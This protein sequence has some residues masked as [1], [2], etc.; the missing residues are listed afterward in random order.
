MGR[1]V[2]R[3][4]SRNRVGR[5]RLWLLFKLSFS[6]V[7]LVALFSRTDREAFFHAFGSLRLPPLLG[8]LL[9]YWVAQI[10][11]SMRWQS[12]LRVE[13]IQVPLR[14]LVLFYFEGMF[15]GLF[16]PTLIGGDI[17]KGYRI[18]QE[19]GGRQAA[20]ASILVERLS[21]LSALVVVALVALLLS[22]DRTAAWQ[23]FGLAAA[24]VVGLVVVFNRTLGASISR[25]LG[26]FHL[27]RVGEVIAAEYA[28]VQRYRGHRRALGQ[29]FVQ[30][31]V[32]Q[33][34]VISGYSLI[35]LALGLSVAFKAFFLLIPVVT[36]V[37]M[38]PVSIAGLGVRE[39]AMVY[40]FGKI[41]LPSASALSLSLTWFLLTVL[42]SLPGALI[43]A[44]C[45]YSKDRLLRVQSAARAE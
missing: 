35:S 1:L 29:A 4:L 39:G 20:L 36:I 24:F 45:D 5:E 16:L 2:A 40:L 43:F 14:R 13:R 28:A 3:E 44:F 10:L 33:V 21:G 26:R 19:T 34:I 9:L 22:R 25:V 6:C 23:I 37:A 41:G 7:F 15:L 17:V 27:G 30:S 11:S 32:I 8:A 31:V 38:I 18:R 42:A 12:L